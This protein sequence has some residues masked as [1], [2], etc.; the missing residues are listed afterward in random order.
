MR[1]AAEGLR[2]RTGRQALKRAIDLTLATTG[3]V[4]LSPVMGAIALLIRM[5]SPGPVLFRQTRVGRNFT[6]FDILKF[7]TM[8]VNAAE[9]GGSLTAAGD[10]RVTPI[11]RWLRATKLDELPQL[12]NVL[13]GDMSF[14]GPRPEMAEY[15]E[16]YRDDYRVLLSVRPGI[17]DPASIAYKNESELLALAANPERAYVEEILPAKIDIS[18]EYLARATPFSDL[19]VIVETLVG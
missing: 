6:P 10:P 7:R 18:R 9:L 4:V 17:T 12:L 14:V 11:G 5:T 2:G 13:R 3:L 1:A 16:R 15:V 19:R 8:V